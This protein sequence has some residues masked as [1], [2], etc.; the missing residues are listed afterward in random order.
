M[1]RDILRTL[2]AEHDALRELFDELKDTTDRGVKKRE[3][4]LEEIEA[5]L[6]PHAQWEEKVFY[7]AFQ[8][9]A[10]R[11]GLLTHAK[12]LAEHHAVE[13]SV[14]PEVH[15]SEPGSPEFAV[16]PRSSAS[17]S[18]TMRGNDHVQDGARAVLGRGTRT[19]R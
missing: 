13:K 8:E 2:K 3:G 9:C 11:D 10:D 17:S 6:L 1:A 5:N 12:A 18:T 4:L 15:A 7:P 19:A 14:I 16:E